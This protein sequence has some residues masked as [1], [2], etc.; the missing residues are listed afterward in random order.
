MLIFCIVKKI[1]RGTP[2]LWVLEFEPLNGEVVEYTAGDYFF[3]RF[4]GADITGEPHPFSTSSARTNN[5]A[6]PL[7][8]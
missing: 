3:I 6:I 2:S 1:Y 7:N 4:K 8:L 5:S